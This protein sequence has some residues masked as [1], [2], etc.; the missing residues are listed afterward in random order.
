MMIGIPLLI[1][2]SFIDTLYYIKFSVNE[3]TD[4]SKFYRFILTD[5]TEYESKDLFE[6]EEISSKL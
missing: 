1:I 5:K 4:F 6:I 3:E 2:Y